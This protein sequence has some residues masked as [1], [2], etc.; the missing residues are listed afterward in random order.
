MTRMLPVI[1]SPE[2]LRRRI[3]GEVL[4]SGDPT[5]EAASQPWN[6]TYTHH[7]SLVV[8]PRSPAD[9]SAAIRHAAD[10]GLAVAVQSTGHGVARPADGVMLISTRELKGVLVDGDAWTACISAGSTWADVLGPAFESGLAP[11]LGS[12]LGVGVVGYTLGGG[13]GWLARK[14][15][16]SVDRVRSIEVV[17]ADGAI[18]RASPD[19]DADLFWALRGAGA[20]SLGV[21]TS[22]E[23]DLVPID[24]LYAGSLFY[25][26]DMARE[27][28]ARYRDWVSGA[29]E[30]LTSSI[31]FVNFPDVEGVPDAVRG[32]SFVVLRGVLIGSDEE[33]SE[34]LRF[35]R[36]WRPPQIDTWRRI[37][38]SAVATISND[39][40]D[41]T[42]SIS[43]TEWL[44]TLSDQ[45][46][47][48]LIAAVLDGE[49]PGAVALAEIRHLGG[50]VARQPEHPSAYTQRQ[51]HHLLQAVGP[52]PDPESAQAL[53][54]RLQG[55]RTELAP[56][57]AGGAYLNFV[58]GSEKVRRSREAFDTETWFRLGG[59]KGAYDPHNIFSHGVDLTAG[60]SSQEVRT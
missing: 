42:A 16:L 48:V 60:G 14:Y 20:G 58:D 59:I 3:N 18:R 11:L 7:P 30:E 5:F 1:G 9:V 32:G 55:L 37:P 35:W 56:H 49:G 45:V 17:T 40:P 12:S 25:A 19:V 23:I 54:N 34:R 33:G 44:D 8:I 41:P 4:I 47:E 13:I 27:I 21:V 28:A 38:F 24:T 15:G 50:A 31:C 39:P 29:P 43:T 10:S 2:E 57:T 46:I 53:S 6:R 52:A 36:D 22:I 26:G 51:H